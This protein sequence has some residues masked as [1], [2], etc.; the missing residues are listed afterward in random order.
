MELFARKSKRPLKAIR[1]FCMECMGMDRRYK[2][3][4]HPIEDIKHCTDKLCPLYDFRL[5][6]NPFLTGRPGGNPEALKKGREKLIE[7]QKK[8]SGIDD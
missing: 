8:T 4:P 1:L 2:N 6:K 7:N 5:G 3:P